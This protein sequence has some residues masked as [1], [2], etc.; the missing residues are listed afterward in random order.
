MRS[1][2]TLFEEQYRLTS[3]QWW[4]FHRICAPLVTH[5]SVWT[6]GW[7]RRGW[8]SQ[9]WVAFMPGSLV[10]T[11]CTAAAP[12]WERRASQAGL[13]ALFW[14]FVLFLPLSDN[15]ESRWGALYWWVSANL[16]KSRLKKYSVRV[17]KV[18]LP[19]K[20]SFCQ[21]EWSSVESLG[22]LKKE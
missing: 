7:T 22:H 4:H 3:P 8:F 6:L 13:A 10:S 2:T 11:C 5:L 12:V 15:S 17:R 9:W 18:L 1:T 14:T 16:C 21:E 20:Y 19:G